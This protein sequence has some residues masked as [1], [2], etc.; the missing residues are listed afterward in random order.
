MKTDKLF[1]RIFLTQPGIL[2]ELIPGIPPDCE[3]EYCAPVIKEQEFRHDGVLT[4]IGDDINLP[5]VFLEAQMQPDKGFY[6]RYFAEV[7]LYLKQY[8]ISRPWRG[9]IILKSR[10]HELGSEIPYR[11]ILKEDVQR[12]YLEDLLSE[13]D[14]SPNLGILQ[15]IVLPQNQVGEA[16]QK[17]LQNVENKTQFTQRLDLIEAILVSKFPQISPE[18]ILKM[19]DLKTADITQTR[20]YRDVFQLGAKEGKQEGEA[21]LIIRQVNRRCGVLSP[22][23]EAQIRSL[24]LNQLESLGEALL[25]FTTIAD[26]EAWL[27]GTHQE[28]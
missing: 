10:G 27:N 20:F 19:L 2:A 22:N 12:L 15:L 11:S 17:L 26:L 25:D 16:A 1:Y 8:N 24:D 21:Q 28:K 9:L 6:G 18:E 4:P 23:Q 13:T 14:L 7:C 5:I 3:F